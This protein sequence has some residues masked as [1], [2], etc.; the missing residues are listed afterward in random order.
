MKV[1]FLNSPEAIKA[2]QSNQLGFSVIILLE[3]NVETID[4]F[5]QE[6]GDFFSRIEEKFEIILIANGTERFVEK[7]ADSLRKKTKFLK[8]FTFYR[9]NTQAVCLKAAVKMIKYDS[10]IVCGSYQQ[11][12]ME[13]LTHAI[14]SLDEE[15]DMVLPCREKRVDPVFNQF[16]SKFFNWLVKIITGFHFSDLSCTVRIVKKSALESLDFYGNMY[17]FLPV[18]AAKKGFKLK[19]VKV[20]HFREMGK[21]G[22][23]DLSDYIVR[24]LDIFVVLFLLQYTKKPFRFFSTIGSGFLFIGGLC[25]TYAMIEKLFLTGGLGNNV[26]LLVGLILISIGMQSAMTGLLG[27]IITFTHGRKRKEYMIDKIVSKRFSGIGRRHN[28]NRRIIQDRREGN[29]KSCAG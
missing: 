25:L 9:K 21:T 29:K 3:E 18:V 10:V 17:R 22:F 4:L 26:F 7:K 23:Y 2:S 6:L 12:T 1:N 20:A 24:I 19:E 13:G 8:I 27:E 5:V 15:T 16:Q 11:I 28:Q 14:N